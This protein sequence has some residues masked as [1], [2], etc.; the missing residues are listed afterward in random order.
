[1]SDD[2]KPR[3]WIYTL[4]KEELQV[5]LKSYNIP[6]EINSTVEELRKLL[7]NYCK[8]KEKTSEHENSENKN[9]KMTTSQYNIQP[10]NGENWECFEQQFEC[11]ILLNEVKEEKKV[12]LL[13]TKITSQ[14]LEVLNC[15][16]T[17][18][19]VTTFSFA[20][21]CQKLRDKYTPKKATAIERA[22][23]RNRNQLPTETIEEYV[24]QLRKLGGKCAFKDLEDQI[25]EK[26][27]DGVY[28]KLI[29]FELL[30]SCT[31]EMSLED[32]I[33]VA[34]T[35]EGALIQTKHKESSVTEMFYYQQ[36]QKMERGNNSKYRNKASKVNKTLTNNNNRESKCFCCGAN[37]HYKKE[38]R[39]IK[40]YCSECGQQGHIYKM[41][42][43]NKTTQKIYSVSEDTKSSDEQEVEA[44]TSAAQMFN[45]YEMY[46]VNVSKVPP[47]YITLNIEGKTLDFQLD[48]GSDV[49]V[50]PCSDC[51]KFFNNRQISDCKVR[52]KNFDQTIS[53]P[54]GIL[55][56]LTVKYK[57][58]QRK[59]NVFVGNNKIPRI[60]GRD[61]LNEFNLWPPKMET[62][63]INF[64]NQINE[65]SIA[66]AELY[67]KKRFTE[68]FS[69]GWGNFKGESIELKLKPEAK[70]K[71]HPVRRVP[72][73]LKEKVKSEISRLI[74]N[75]R[76]VPVEYSQWGTPVVPILKPDGSVRL[77][78]DYK[79]TINPHLEV[80]HFPLPHIDEI[81]ETLKN[82][83]YFCE[84]DLKEAYLQAPLEKKSQEL[85][86]I[87]TEVGTYK[88]QYLPYGVST[89]PGSFQRLMY[90][91][92][93]DISNTSVFIDNIY[94]CG[95][96]INDTLATLCKVLTK[97]QECEFK[98]KIEKCKL[99]TTSIDVFGFKITKNDISVNRKNI[100]PLLNAEVPKNITMLKS[101][102]GKVTYYSRFLKDMAHIIAP[103]YDCTK[104]KKLQWTKEC[105]DSFNKIKQKL[106]CVS[107][108]RHYNPDL[109]LILTCDASQVALGAIISNRDENGVVRPIAYASKKLNSTEVKYSAIDKEA[110][111]IIFGVTKFYNYIYGRTFELETDNAALVR[112]FGPTK[113]IPKMAAKRLQH[114]AIFLSA[115]QYKIK[116][117]KTSVN[118]A[119]FLSRTLTENCEENMNMHSLCS[120]ANITNTYYINNSEIEMLDWKLI[121][122]ETK[123][124]PILSTVIR[125]LSDGWPDVKNLNK[126]LLSYYNKKTEL[127]VDRDC[128]FWGYRIIIPTEL[129]VSVLNELHK[130]HFGIVRMKQL[131][132]S[133]FWWQGLDKE[134]ESITFNCIT[135]M[136]N[137]K[138]P[139]KTMQPWPA[140]PSV[141]YRIHADFLG[142]FYNKMYLVVIDSYSKWPEI[143]EMNNITASKTIEVFKNIFSRFGY[144]AHLVTDNGP[145]FTSS[146]FNDY[147]KMIN[148]KHT[149]SP[150]Y[151]PATNGAAERFVE[152]FKSHVTKIK[153]SGNSLIS[154]VNLFLFDY[155]NMP[156][157]LTGVTPA[158]L[159][160]GRELRNRFTLLRP[161]AMVDKS[162]DLMEKQVNSKVGNRKTDFVLGEKVMVR[163]YRKGYKPW[164]LGIIIEESVP[165]ITYIVD[166]DGNRWKRHVNQL[167]RC[168]ESLEIK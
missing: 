104:N 119:D 147:C 17:P 42:M 122:K 30:K 29:Q 118:P 51:E 26:L 53:E 143:Y 151:H 113:G 31:T 163:D 82:G 137:R 32:T 166:V 152:T 100:E 134:I 156:H 1:M 112:I 73:A 90:N 95:E 103:L 131:A 150:P 13:L 48:T 130:S 161:P 79:T 81:F 57:N 120:E 3:S 94:I 142:P 49:T 12:P 22:T 126:D 168:S 69:P 54:V 58:E 20:E 121:Q 138:N 125:Y 107:N 153:E 19:K 8:E 64:N 117:I 56:G 70:P 38:C 60:L 76:I 37:N 68:V 39:L 41:C 71:F 145:T 4:K 75:G 74:E 28:S 9:T 99:F 61:W 155:R 160:L 88:Y 97:L 91:K 10:F 101:F 162:Y 72:L 139:Q 23:F 144:P 93:R 36:G 140:P 159:M 65:N 124:D 106:A 148:V 149:Y 50:I 80:D 96:T 47:L 114:Y 14:V 109:P 164:I 52:F 24:L 21:L 66:E 33:I 5:T 133:F 129:R 11:L 34:R 105:T 141:W 44:E 78:G 92:L 15:L 35:V 18:K 115:F 7:S 123:K 102:L 46:S 2:H 136:K 135:C 87:V 116:H 6:F 55:K 89:G 132:R 27:I 157:S 63:H 45:E 111:S 165:N 167:L 84:L 146:E 128:L 83:Q 127:S 108:L 67:V 154:A 25:K 110:M 158:R 40:K 62:Q 86:T 16:C 85:T 43:R 59:L 98:L 77:C